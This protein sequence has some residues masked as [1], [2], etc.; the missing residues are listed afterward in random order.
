MVRRRRIAAVVS[1]ALAALFLA[2]DLF[3]IRFALG[4][5]SVA[6]YPV[7]FFAGL[8]VVL[9]AREWRPRRRRAR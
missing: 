7:L 2:L 6:I 5:T 3:D 4:R 8:A 9:L 1:F